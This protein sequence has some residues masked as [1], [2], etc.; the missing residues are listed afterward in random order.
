MIDTN[1]KADALASAFIPTQ[2][3]Q[4]SHNIPFE[5]SSA[6]LDSNLEKAI[7]LFVQNGAD[8]WIDW[9]FNNLADQYQARYFVASKSL[10]IDVFARANR[11]PTISMHNFNHFTT[12][13]D[14]AMP[15]FAKKLATALRVAGVVCT[16]KQSALEEVAHG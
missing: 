8:R 4:K 16:F 7:E 10:A 15:R 14:M 2:R 6:I 11:P 5:M 3:E 12:P 9:H 1:K 13:H